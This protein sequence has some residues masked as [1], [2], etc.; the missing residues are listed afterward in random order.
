MYDFPNIFQQMTEKLWQEQK[1]K[2]VTRSQMP[3]NVLLSSVELILNE[4]NVLEE[5]VRPPGLNKV[6]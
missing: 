5:V 2:Y 1:S 4:D 6:S 3:E